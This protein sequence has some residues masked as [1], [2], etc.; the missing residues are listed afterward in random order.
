M[1]VDGAGAQDVALASTTN[2]RMA[3]VESTKP[4]AAEEEV[5]RRSYGSWRTMRAADSMTGSGATERS[6]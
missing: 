1:R 2:E 6:G 5:Q 3:L 4:L